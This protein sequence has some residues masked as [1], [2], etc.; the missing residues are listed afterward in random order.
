MVILFPL[1]LNLYAQKVDS[2]PLLIVK[3]IAGRVIDETN[4]KLINTEQK[5]ILNI[6]IIDFPK[7][8]RNQSSKPAFALAKISVPENKKLSFGI[9]YSQPVKIWIDN[10]MVFQGNDNGKFFFKEIGY[11]M[12]SFQDTFSVNLHKGINRIIVESFTKRKSFVYLRELTG[13][14]ENP[15]SKFLPLNLINQTSFVWGFINGEM[16]GFNLVKN[17]DYEISLLDSLFNEQSLSKL[18]LEYPKANI[19]KNLVLNTEGTVKND[20]FA[21][22]NYPNGILMMALL[23]LSK[24]T[25]DKSYHAFVTKYCSFIAA[26]LPLFKKQYFRDHDL[27]TSY[28]RIFRKSMLDDAGAPTLPFVELS[29]Q[30]KIHNYDSLIIEMADY[31]LNGQSRLTD[32]TYCRPEPEKWT[33]WAD[34]LFMSIPLLVRTGKLTKLNKYFNEAANQIINFNKYLFDPD[35]KLY[36]H[37]W[38][39]STN[40]K[41]AIYWGRAN[42]WVLWAES[43]ALGYLPKDNI[44]YYEVE[45]IFIDHINGI[46]TCQDRSGMWHQV[47]NDKSSFEETSCTAMFIVALSKGITNGILNRNLSVNVF[48]AWGSLQ[49]KISSEGIVKDISCGT[50]IKN[51]VKYYEE[52]KTY[53]ND[54]RGLGA[55]IEAGIEVAKLENYLKLKK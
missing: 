47:L 8:F 14:D 36:K 34:D 31:V 13:V 41:S 16:K 50:E 38:F 28:Y 10:K 1:V 5:T 17:Y 24:E 19:I 23:N 40:E 48:K 29:L 22:W 49:T 33:I 9:A 44:Y 25:G 20:S 18:N 39:S 53:D 52:R 30:D 15:F 46:L 7:I 11:S 2:T 43:D 37:G 51:N 3:K 26:N 42:G 4:F 12:F 45:R 54:P 21:D 32:G 6:Q 35:K 55:I 27:R